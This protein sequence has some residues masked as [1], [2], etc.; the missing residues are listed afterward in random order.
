MVMRST[1]QP[2]EGHRFVSRRTQI[3]SCGL[4]A[5]AE[6]SQRQQSRPAHS[7]APALSRGML[8]TKQQLH[9]LVIT[10]LNE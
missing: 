2:V 5:T 6:L 9:S 1:A 10:L 4:G 7:T 8:S 3:V